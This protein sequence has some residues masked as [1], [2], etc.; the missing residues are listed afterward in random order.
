MQASYSRGICVVNG[1]YQWQIE[2]TSKQSCKPQTL[3]TLFMTFVSAQKE[4]AA[5]HHVN[6]YRKLNISV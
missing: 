3:I 5:Q 2:F 1:E 4:N 6:I